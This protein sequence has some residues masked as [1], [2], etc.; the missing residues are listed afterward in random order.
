MPKLVRL[1]DATYMLVAGASF[2]YHDCYVKLVAILWS[3]FSVIDAIFMVATIT[4]IDK[5][6]FSQENGDNLDL[7]SL[8]S[9]VFQV[10]QKG[11]LE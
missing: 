8:L 6:G 2:Q 5:K 9:F 7:G 10:R 4:E 3:H 1:S 11:L